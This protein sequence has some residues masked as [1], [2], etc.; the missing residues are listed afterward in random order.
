MTPQEILAAYKS[1]KISTAEVKEELVKLKKTIL[2]Y[3]LSEGQKGLWMLQKMVPSMNAYNVPI[4]F[5]TSQALDI[6]LFK[7]AC[8]FLLKQYPILTH[9]IGEDKGVPFQRVQPSQNLYFKTEDVSS[10]TSDEIIKLL[11]KRSKQPFVLDKD[12]LMRV[13][14]LSKS[15]QE[16]FVLIVVHHIVFDGSSFQL[17]F[18]TL[19]DSYKTLLNGE[20]TS[21]IRQAAGYHDFVVLEQNLLKGEKGEEHLQFWQKELSGTL[22]VMTFYEKHPDMSFRRFEGN[23]YTYIIDENMTQ[24][25][26][27][28]ATA[29]RMNLSVLFLGVF[30]VLLHHYTGLQDIIVGMP[31]MG[32][33][34][35]RFESL[36]GYF[37]NMMPIRTR[38]IGDTSFD[39][40]LKQLQRKLIEG[41][42]HA[43]YPF[44]A[45]VKALN[46]HRSTSGSPVFQV[47]FAF[48]NFILAS[49]IEHFQE[50]YQKT[51]AVEFID[52][53]HQ[54]GEYEL[55]MEILEQKQHYILNLKY[56]S[57]LFDKQQIHEMMAAYITLINEVCADPA[58]KSGSY[59][60]LSPEENAS[61]LID[62]NR[63][64]NRLPNL[65]IH[66]LFEQQVLKNPDHTAV[67][68]KMNRVTYRQLNEK[69]NQLS[70]HLLSCGLKEE[71]LV[72]ICVERSIDMITGILA[73][74]KAGGAY[75]PI[76]PKS[77]EERISLIL[78][79]CETRIVL[80]QESLGSLL[81]D[82]I[83]QLIFLDNP[84]EFSTDLS[85]GYQNQNG[86][87]QNQGDSLESDGKKLA[88]VMFTSG[89]T[90]TP[91]G[92]CITHKNIS[93]LVNHR[94]FDFLNKDARVLQY[95]PLSFDAS[96][97]EIWGA[98]CNGGTL[99][100]APEG[101]LSPEELGQTLKDGRI[102]VLW[103]T[104]AL[105][106]QI[107]EH[108]VTALSGVKYLLAGGDVLHASHIKKVFENNPDIILINGYGPTENTTFSTLYTMDKETVLDNFV[109]I[110]KPLDNTTCYIVNENLIPVPFGVKGELLVG[111]DGLAR[112]YLNNPELTRE[113]FIKNPF[114]NDSDS[115]LYRT[116]DLVCYLPDNSIRFIGRK[117][118]QVKI[119][120]FRIEPGEVEN[121]L[122]LHPGIKECVVVVKERDSGKMLVAYYVEKSPQKRVEPAE[123]SSY[124][125][126]SLPPYMIPSFFICLEK[127]PVTT[128]GKADRKKLARQRVTLVQREKKA[129][130]NSEIQTAILKIWQEVLEVENIGMEDGFF[131]VGGDSITAVVVSERIKNELYVDFDTTALFKYP[132]IREISQ[133]L[134]EQQ[135]LTEHQFLAER[136]AT[137]Y[138][139]DF[140]E[141]RADKENR[142]EHMESSVP[143]YNVKNYNKDDR[144]DAPTDY[145]SDF[146]RKIYEENCPDYY[147][148]SMAVIGISCHFPGAQD[149][150]RFWENLCQAKESICFY[151]H[152]ELRGLGIAE[153]LIRHPGY[154]PIQSTIEDKDKF[155]HA[156]FN[157]S[158]R[159]AQF[160]DPQ[161]RLLMQH[162][163][164]AFEDAGY[165]PKENP[166]TAVFV[167][168]GNNFYNALPPKEDT[169]MAGHPDGY[170]A[171]VLAQ[172]GTIPTMISHKLGL[173]GPSYFVHANCSSS[174]IGLH[175]AFQS[176]K[177]NEADYA[178]VGAA[179]VFSES[180]I[181]Y[182][183]KPGLNFSSDG[184]LKAFDASAD[185]MVG[186]EGVAVVLL[187]KASLAVRDKDH[188]YAIVRGI[189]VNNDGSDK[190]GYYAPSI[191]GQTEV[192]RQVMDRAGVHPESI[193]YIEAHG[194]GTKLGDPIEFNALCEHFRRF[195][196]KK[197]FCGI[198]S[199]KTNI[200]HLDCAAGLA[201][202]IK[203]SL[204]LH[205]RQIPP[206]LNY[207]KANPQIDID[208][209]PFY[210]VKELEELMPRTTPHLAALSSFGLGGTN[211]HA[212][213]EQYIKP[214]S[215]PEH[216]AHE[217]FLI[218][219][220]AKRADC[221][222][223]YASELL[224][225]LRRSKGPDIS[226]SSLAYTLQ[227]GREGMQKRV[228]FVIRDLDELMLQLDL[229]I[230]GE[231]DP[232]ITVQG[233]TLSSKEGLDIFETDEDHKELLHQWI[234][235]GKLAKLARLWVRGVEIEWNCFY[236]HGL[237]GFISLPTY[238]FAKESH[239]LGRASLPALSAAPDKKLSTGLL[240]NQV[241]P[242][243]TL[244][245]RAGLV[246]KTEISPDF[247]LVA[248]YTANGFPMLLL[249][250][251]IEM[252]TSAMRQILGSSPIEIE[253]IFFLAPLVV[254]EK[255][256]IHFVLSQTQKKDLCY[257]FRIQSDEQDPVIF[258]HGRV[259]P[260]EDPDERFNPF[261]SRSLTDESLM[262]TEEFFER[263][264]IF[265]MEY[266]ADLRCLNR[267]WSEE[268]LIFS[269]LE[270]KGKNCH[271]TGN[272]NERSSYHCH[273]ELID[274]ALQT[275]IGLD[276]EKPE[277]DPITWIKHIKI[278]SDLPAKIISCVTSCES[279]EGYK[280]TLLNS[281]GKVMMTMG[282][283]GSPQ[284]LSQDITYGITWVK[285]GD[286]G[287]ETRGA[288][289][290]DSSVLNNN[291]V[292][293]SLTGQNNRDVNNN[294][295]DHNK[296]F[297]RNNNR[298]GRS[299]Q[300]AVIVSS[301]YT[302]GLEKRIVQ[303][304]RQ[305]SR[306]DRVTL[307]QMG[308]RTERI[309]DN[310]WICGRDDLDAFDL[311]LANRTS[312]TSLFFLAGFAGNDKESAL[313]EENLDR[314]Y[315]VNP[316][317]EL[318]RLV[319]YL[320]RNNDGHV[321]DCFIIT[322]DTFRL[323]DNLINPTGAGITGLS[324]AM[325]QSDHHLRVRN[326]DISR[327]DLADIPG[328]E[329]LA[330]Q[331]MA[332]P[333]SQRGDLVKLL[334][335]AAYGQQFTPFDMKSIKQ[336]SEFNPD[337]NPNGVYVIAGGSGNVGMV[338]TRYL[339]QKYKAKVIWIGRSPE[340]S[341]QIIQKR[342]SL[343][344]LGQP[345]L[346][347]QADVT[348]LDQ[349]KD[350][351]RIIKRDCHAINGA[352][353]SS[354]VMNYENT[355]EKSSEKEFRQVLDVKVQGSINFYKAFKDEPLDFMC[356][357]SSAQAFSF[358]GAAHFSAYAAAITFCDAFCRYLQY[359]SIFP[360]GIINWGFWKSPV[361]AAALNRSLVKGIMNSTGFLEYKEGFDCFKSFITL[362]QQ[363]GVNQ[364]L[365][366]R[367][368]EP[369]KRLMNINSHEK[370]SICQK[371]YDP[372]LKSVLG[373]VQINS[374]NVLPLLNG[375]NPEE[376]YKWVTRLL[377]SQLQ[378]LGILSHE[379][380]SQSLSA[381][382]N[383]AGILEK[384]DRWFIEAVQ[385][386]VSSG[387]LTVKDG[388]VRVFYT[389]DE[390]STRTW[391]IWDQVKDSILDNSG[392]KSHME[393]V[394]RCLRNLPEI[395]TGRIPA[396][397]I[398]FP[399]SSMSMVETIYK[400]SAL[401]DYFNTIVAD[402]AS[403][404]VKERLK[405]DPAAEIRIIEI[406]AGTGGTT[407]MVLPK[408]KQFQDRIQYWYT[409]ISKSFL[410]FAEKSYQDEFP[411]LRYKVWDVQKAPETCGI[412]TGNY[413]IAIATNV[414]H[415]T[416]DITQTLTHAKAALKTNGVILINEVID[417][418]IIGTLSFGLT[419]GWWLY[420]D[421][422]LRIPGSPMVNLP[423]W[424]T[425]LRET[426]FRQITFPAQCAIQTGQQIIV[427][428]SNG[429]I[430]QMVTSSSSALEQK[431]RSKGRNPVSKTPGTEEK[432]LHRSTLYK[433]SESFKRDTYIQKTD[434]FAANQKQ[435]TEPVS[436]ISGP[437][438]KA[439]VLSV[440]KDELSKALKMPVES[441]EEQV[442]FSD[443]GV[444][445]II[446]VNF[447]EQINKRLNIDLNTAIV[448]DYTTVSKLS[449]YIV[450]QE[451]QSGTDYSRDSSALTPHDNKRMD[452]YLMEELEEKFWTD[453]ISSHAL[454][455]AL[456]ND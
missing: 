338:I 391:E 440:I 118:N 237:P 322:T 146:S 93:R 327:E 181:G 254:M 116:G 302:N 275:R 121:H 385:I 225:F 372:L 304:Y 188:I 367:A 269:E 203:L 33:T 252:V 155:D 70:L 266:N 207:E 96:T 194:T 132:N 292:R 437:G 270:I 308:N 298:S 248:G 159:D 361:K 195:T 345:P 61:I 9:M 4:C 400:K 68:D 319:Q 439:T 430:R 392:M 226:L 241:D 405:Q 236:P 293:S 117:D 387:Y 151:S 347:I 316:E 102:S 283:I 346:Y 219:L 35:E 366:L 217:L 224:F 247:P 290:N 80:T 127:I 57:H 341:T 285:K 145:K 205:N 297:Y 294:L 344:I 277:A 34:E 340:T 154:V 81:P 253:E 196:S 110:G 17:L 403:A 115:T 21:I 326:I 209:S 46:I 296:M 74:L 42:S 342:Q 176:L 204:A 349:L 323:Q 211:T 172:N 278:F 167:S 380:T 452:N 282:Q 24:K 109:P 13:Y 245:Q 138:S 365:C 232:K 222:A 32:R 334:D 198:G 300:S 135:A 65:S 286:F 260:C 246:F 173:K 152:E 190:V 56:N 242:K 328:Q 360:V 368:S 161:F 156:F 214:Q 221:L 299:A 442:A 373:T 264:S 101:T 301:G 276:M 6:E 22:P 438:I 384:Y 165:I 90:G 201:G 332:Q 49:G 39:E 258:C 107:A 333:P 416:K 12:N 378:R 239:P 352:I 399:K 359:R 128:N 36:V 41:M 376:F 343:A 142:A 3:P 134:T 271:K 446:S 192:I 413:D 51:L 69:A 363:G 407:A 353:F 229:F 284:D 169:E 197:R 38:K 295:S 58:K 29:L 281:D 358:S 99:V 249:S 408:L 318:L 377:F 280:L 202:F 393:L 238:P 320:K 125:K 397:D 425:L 164:K 119:R 303:Y 227:R 8:E 364:A 273:P 350:A 414:L 48:Q 91:K 218:P 64:K 92:V 417:N 404:L 86:L 45:L 337:F 27:S 54:E 330:E 191:S 418:T 256:I 1:G 71:S 216:L 129:V 381:L 98:L 454:L 7:A 108:H 235:K 163:W 124:L 447:I 375:I 120:G 206:S 150:N 2:E 89:T 339:I 28:L 230:K 386:L 325:A 432:E 47:S 139:I 265:G 382:R 398:L 234:K 374:D 193:S 200:G 307:I 14:V 171:W 379:D 18:R 212:I 31:T 263:L 259:V 272:Q 362:L 348:N 112:G 355:V 449:D 76:D 389:S 72:G 10:L 251:A 37:I 82:Q 53:I 66:K 423:T 406:G 428:E 15:T 351:V 401:S 131:D 78:K 455:E 87:L 20:K 126:R 370:V 412:E 427:A 244:R 23:T 415:A 424:E 450:V 312:I 114:D 411:F 186:G 262:S 448:F 177:S 395:L 130:P 67:T 291:P 240:I 84:K 60:I 77:P 409:D 19:M 435:Q 187:K 436:G 106:S 44:P 288:G 419:D 182:I 309:T 25:I 429:F 441:I 443:Y 267:I 208:S 113:K 306:E 451:F 324:Y 40:L 166:K 243:L 445:S 63:T 329:R 313:Q 371:Q 30:K 85:T 431:S 233:D 183:H 356:Y 175:S 73:I 310:E 315:L 257:E 220:S 59:N 174:L 456:D 140:K 79:A 26:R 223:V 189:S 433:R 396:T 305:K 383:K 62:L 314:L 52:G 100:I 141:D 153:E 268:G 410:L 390:D 16:S 43:A 388:M 369:V 105:F 123:L 160:M 422:H 261:W 289:S 250:A 11:D 88:Y 143:E 149:H 255:R 111:G 434:G 394:V 421:A 321:M 185:G 317:I 179:N 215:Q 104:S 336:I 75:L 420:E 453:E 162:S 144:Y 170:A 94:G 180:N 210:V 95:A 137:S 133:F 402:I 274:I 168:T 103:L 231:A 335:G 83:E 354:V 97:F 444:D 55:E 136:Q 148:E 5:K 184:H 199:V 357:F 287:P 50:Q 426:G 178:L 122:S 331:I 147:K 228:A 213:L 157:L 311:C 279:E 158:P